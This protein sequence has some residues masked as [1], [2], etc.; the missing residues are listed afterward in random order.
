[1]LIIKDNIKMDIN[2]SFG[3]MVWNK[4]GSNRQGTSQYRGVV[5]IIPKF[6]PHSIA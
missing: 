5:R 4:L 1:M 2:K 3:V 6:P